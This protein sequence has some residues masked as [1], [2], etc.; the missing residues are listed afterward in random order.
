[1]FSHKACLHERVT[2][3][4][5]EIACLLFL[6]GLPFYSPFQL[7]QLTDCVHTF[8][9]SQFDFATASVSQSSLSNLRLQILYL[10]AAA[11]CLFSV[12]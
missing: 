10:S 3:E 7:N 6:F 12:L 1:M 4:L 5:S 2:D 9:F 8:H 11:N